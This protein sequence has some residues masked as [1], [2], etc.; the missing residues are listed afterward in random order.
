L[1]DNHCLEINFQLEA[2]NAFVEY[3]SKFYGGVV[4]SLHDVCAKKVG[5]VSGILEET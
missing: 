3:E 4:L 1:S 5:S 2:N